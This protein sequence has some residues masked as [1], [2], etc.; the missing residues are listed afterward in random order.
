MWAVKQQVAPRYQLPNCG[1]TQVDFP[2]SDSLLENVLWLH[3]TVF[4]LD[5]RCPVDT[6]KHVVSMTSW[7]LMME[8]DIPVTRESYYRTVLISTCNQNEI[9]KSIHSSACRI[10]RMSFNRK[11]SLPGIYSIFLMSVFCFPCANLTP[12]SQSISDPSRMIK[13]QD[14]II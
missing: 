10:A 9:Q 8:E 14:D 13:N 4:D 12:T 7:V 11:M 3:E 5:W 6:P 2:E 1:C